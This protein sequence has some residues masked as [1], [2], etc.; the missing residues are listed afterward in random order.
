MAE[1]TTKKRTMRLTQAG[2]NL[3]TKTLMNKPFRVTRAMLG[4]GEVPAGMSI[5]DMTSMSHPRMEIPIVGYRQTGTGSA[6]L[7]FEIINAELAEG[8]RACEAGIYAIDPD[9][10]E[11][12]L[13]AYR[14]TGEYWQWIPEA[15]SG[16][17]L[18]E[19]WNVHVAIAQSD[20]ITINIVDSVGGVTRAEY[21]DHIKDLNPHSNFLQI[22]NQVND[23]THLFVST[24]GARRLDRMSIEDA[25]VKILGENA[26]T[27]PI[28]NGRLNNL[29]IELE[30]IGIRT[31]VAQNLDLSNTFVYE[32]FDP[33]DEIDDTAIKVTSIT[34]DSRTINVESLVGLM[35][36]SWYTIT[37]GIRKESI[38]VKSLTCGVGGNDTTYR[39]IAY[40]DVVN[41]FNIDNT[42]LYR[43]TAGIKTGKVTGSADRRAITW[44]PST[45]WKGQ[46]AQTSSL[47]EL[48]STLDKAA[49]FTLEGDYKFA[50]GGFMT[51]DTTIVHRHA[52]A[53]QMIRT[54]GG[55]GTWKLQN[56]D[57]TD[58]TGN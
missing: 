52:I 21:Y 1:E 31:M 39:I 35:E 51:L 11:E 34:A 48:E 14:N 9:T 23:C 53:I 44:N 29:E 28:M 30:N 18:N 42:F 47:V 15:S 13:Y 20:N 4:D 12:V 33:P 24:G 3:F 37:D 26:S 58:Y 55:K 25:R 10:N 5:E 57:G 7:E 19:V 36:G 50:N 38:Q 22:G 8:F 45:D 43:S 32:D 17:I 49:N 2:M 6:V 41:S 54:G 16:E 40:S 46:G 56:E 27:L